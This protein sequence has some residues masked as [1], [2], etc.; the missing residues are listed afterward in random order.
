[1]KN[2]FVELLALHLHLSKEHGTLLFDTANFLLEQILEVPAHP[3]DLCDRIF[4]FCLHPSQLH[5]ILPLH[6]LVPR[7]KEFRELI[8]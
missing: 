6:L 2:L 3:I 5:L 8:F 7:V 1:M 4:V